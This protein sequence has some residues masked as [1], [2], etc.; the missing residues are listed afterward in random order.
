MPVF[1]VHQLI[2]WTMPPTGSDRHKVILIAVSTINPS[3]YYAGMRI[4]ILL[5][6]LFMA[7]CALPV[8]IQ[9]P[10]ANIKITE[11]CI[12]DNPKVLMDGFL[13][14]LKAQLKSYG[15][16]TQTWTAYNP[17]GCRYWLE[18]TANWRWDFA[19]IMEYAELKLYEHTTLI[20]YAEFNN[21]KPC[22]FC[23]PQYGSAAS[24]LKALTAPLFA[25][26]SEFK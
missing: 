21:R 20:G 14:E 25:Q 19:M 13:P 23:S 22:L 4:L 11:L 15:I 6:V 26:K 9:P 18:Y 17:E 8:V 3:V 16:A 10:A 24:K 7:G 2:T 5:T 1:Y 12:V